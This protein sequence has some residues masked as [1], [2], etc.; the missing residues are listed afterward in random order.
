MIFLT[1]PLSKMSSTVTQPSF[2]SQVP[3]KTYYLNDRNEGKTIGI[4]NSYDLANLGW[5]K[6]AN[7]HLE[8]HP[9]DRKLYRKSNLQEEDDDDE[10]DDDEEDNEEKQDDIDYKAL[11]SDLNISIENEPFNEDEDEDNEEDDDESD[12]EKRKHHDSGDDNSNSD[13]SNSDNDD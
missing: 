3:T 10:D 7:K 8:I 5:V 1:L 4:F 13:D 9:E 2:S 6:H 11:M 12:D